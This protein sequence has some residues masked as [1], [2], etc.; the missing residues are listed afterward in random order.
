MIKTI[1][2]QLYKGTSVKSMIYLCLYIWTF[3]ISFVFRKKF[4]DEIGFNIKKNGKIENFVFVIIRNLTTMYIILPIVKLLEKMI[5]LG[6]TKKTISDSLDI[7][8]FSEV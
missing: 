8:S 6:T 2:T 5:L 1:L 3:T 7:D 4:I